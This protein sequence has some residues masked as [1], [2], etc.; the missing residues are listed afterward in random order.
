MSRVAAFFDLDRTLLPDAAGMHIAAGLVEA[1]LVDGAE[2][3]GALMFRPVAAALRETYRVTGETWLSVWMSK[4]GMRSLAGRPADRLAKAGEHIADRL[5]RRVFGEGRRLI[6][7]HH[8]QGHVVVVASSAWRG[9]VA[10]LAER[11]GA[12]HVIATDYE[13]QDGRFTG[14]LTGAWLFGPSKAEAVRAFADSH[15]LHLSDSYAYSDAWYDRFLLESVGHP[16]VVN[17]DLALR[18]LA[19]VR[20][21]PVLA[22]RGRDAEPRAGFEMYDLARVLLHPL[23]LPFRIEAEGLENIPRDCG[24]ILASNHRSYLD[25]LVVAALASRRGRKL[26]FLGKREIFEAPVVRNI[27]RATG[28]I[29]VDRGTGSAT[30]LRVAI[31][32]LDRR[33]AV[34]ILPQGTIP[35]GESFFDPALKAKS[36]VARLA[37]SSG[38]PVIPIALWGTERIWPRSARVPNLAMTKETVFARIGEPMWLKAADGEEEGKELLETL[39][40]DVMRRIGSLLPDEV[41]APAQPTQSEIEAA[42]P[43]RVSV[44]KELVSLPTGFATSLVRR[45]LRRT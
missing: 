37:L 27:V 15:D 26:R 3:V 11:L 31:D 23:M 21:W 9:I 4:R 6:E 7:R 18:A 12:D 5:E 35:R 25:G 29:P 36:G 30:P 28:Q 1:G 2:R 13:V 33:E 19:R 20:G 32:A 40:G 14:D 8:A 43:P 45:L 38:A 24:C 16:R 17:P 44:A 10:P 41:R 34:A 22:F 42:S 39:A